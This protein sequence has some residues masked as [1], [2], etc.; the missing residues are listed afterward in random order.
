MLPLILAAVV[1]FEAAQI[2]PESAQILERGLAAAGRLD[3]IVSM[4][5]EVK[6]SDRPIPAPVGHH[7][8]V[9][10][11]NFSYPHQDQNQTVF[12]VLKDISFE[13]VPGKRLAIVGPSGSGKTTITNLLLRFWNYSQGQIKLANKELSDFSQEFIYTY[14]GTWPD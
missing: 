3:E 5:P 2:L 10:D 11:L 1:S 4:P 12:P 13:L 9:I 6:D 8:E 7:L 14:C